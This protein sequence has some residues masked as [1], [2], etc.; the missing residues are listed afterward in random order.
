MQQDM[1]LEDGGPIRPV[2]PTEVAAKYDEVL[3]QLPPG[4]LRRIDVHGLH[5][6]ARLLQ[7]SDQYFQLTMDDPTD[8]KSAR[9]YLNIQNQI[10]RM[11]AA[12]GMTPAD[13]KRLAFAPPEPENPMDQ[14]LSEA[15]GN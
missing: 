6:L 10:H 7:V 5:N 2:M 8:H 3:S 15:Q 11:S 14:W 1:T 13:R 12:Y 4:V 9:L